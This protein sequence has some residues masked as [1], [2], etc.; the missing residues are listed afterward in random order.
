M[1]KTKTPILQNLLQ[2]CDPAETIPALPESPLQWPNI[3]QQTNSAGIACW[4][5]QHG[6][7]DPSPGNRR[8]TFREYLQCPKTVVVQLSDLSANLS[9]PQWAFIPIDPDETWTFTF[10]HALANQPE[11]LSLITGQSGVSYPTVSN[12]TAGNTTDSGGDGQGTDQ[13]AKNAAGETNTTQVVGAIVGGALSGMALLS[14]AVIFVFYVW[15][16]RGEYRRSGLSTWVRKQDWQI[17]QR[18][19]QGRTISVTLPPA[20]AWESV[21]DVTAQSEERHIAPHRRLDMTK[22]IV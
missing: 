2:K 20:N 1:R 13:G 6:Q 3:C 10:T 9:I 7:V 11:V 4:S 21:G 5:C 17:D 22:G 15:R 14:S 8:P 16:R 12:N 18:M 19:S